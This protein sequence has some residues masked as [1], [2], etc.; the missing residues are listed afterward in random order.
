VQPTR[1]SSS[2]NGSRSR[3]AGP[4][5]LA[6]LLLLA[7]CG[8]AVRP[9]PAAKLPARTI[10]L[11]NEAGPGAYRLTVETG[12]PPPPSPVENLAPGSRGWQLNGPAPLLGGAATKGVAGYVSNP[13]PLPGERELLY[14]SAPGAAFARVQLWRLGWYGGKGGRLYLESSLLPLPP[15]PPCHHDQRTG[16]TECGWRPAFGLRLPSSFPSGVYLFKIVAADGGQ[17][18]AVF[19]LRARRPAKA[20]VELPDATWEAYNGFG[21]D[22]LYREP[23]AEPVAATGTDQGVAVSFQRPYATLSGAG[24][25]FARE[26]AAVWFFERSGLPVSYTTISALDREPQQLRGVRVLIDVGHSEY[27]SWRAFGALQRLVAQGGSLLLLS[28]DLLGWEV[29]FAPAGRFASLPG[30]PTQ[31]MISYKEY[32]PLAPPQLRATGPFPAGPAGRLTGTA[33]AGC[34]TPR[35]PGSPPRYRYYPLTITAQSPRW[36]LHGSG[37]AAGATLPGIVGYEL[38]D[39]SPYAPPGTA[40]VALSPPVPCLRGDGAAPLP[41]DLAEATL[42]YTPAGGFVFASGTLGWLYGLQPLPGVSP[43]LPDR[44]MPALETITR[45]LIR[46]A[47]GW[48]RRSL[49]R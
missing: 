48:R 36:L 13:A 37:L 35:L 5:L 14:I 18:D 9:K 29:S 47:I 19:V 2:S 3:L 8:A 7:G 27:W 42:Y 17:A 15:A 26:I 49:L 11:A 40:V 45:N 30:Q 21:G 43:D 31:T 23:G 41:G 25:L 4:C 6:L 24:Q 32:A 28:S 44:P 16:L 34:I 22:D 39:R 10:W 12:G 20:V 33:F 38:D 46:K 1:W